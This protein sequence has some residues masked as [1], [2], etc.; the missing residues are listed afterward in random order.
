MYLGYILVFEILY[1]K[2][3]TI[4]FNL[5]LVTPIFLSRDK[6]LNIFEC[7]YRKLAEDYLDIDYHI[8]F[9][10]KYQ[11]TGQKCQLYT[12]VVAIKEVAVIQ[13]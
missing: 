2:F 11:G 3:I 10:C 9:Q 13:R 6:S 8:D 7:T 12:G 4:N 5:F 1:N